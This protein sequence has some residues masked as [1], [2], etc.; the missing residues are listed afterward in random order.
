MEYITKI[1]KRRIFNQN[2]T[3]LAMVFKVKIV[4]YINFMIKGIKG[5][6]IIAFALLCIVHSNVIDCTCV[7]WLIISNIILQQ[8]WK[9]KTPTE[10]PPT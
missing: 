5:D 8:N 6:T 10:K 1:L 7:E 4:D 2:Q 9:N 3:S